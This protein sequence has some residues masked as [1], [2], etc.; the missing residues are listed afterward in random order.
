MSELKHSKLNSLVSVW[1]GA[2]FY[3]VLRDGVKRMVKVAK[4]D[5]NP[6]GRTE[7]LSDYKL[8]MCNVILKCP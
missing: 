7:I 3:F 4:R 6:P 1:G 5:M 2:A 8:I